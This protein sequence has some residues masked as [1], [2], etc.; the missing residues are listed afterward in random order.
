[1]ATVNEMEPT[2][3]ALMPNLLAIVAIAAGDHLVVKPL[4][5]ARGLAAGKLSVCRWFLVHFAANLA[6]CLTAWRALW[7]T[8]SDPLNSMNVD[9]YNDSSLFGCTSPWPLAIINSVHVYHMVGG[10]SLTSADYFHHL[11]FIPALGLPG[12]FLKW[13]PVMPAGAFFI[14]GLPG[15]TSYL[16]LGLSKLGLVSAMTEKRCSAN[17]NT[18]VR[19]PG[20]LFTCFCI[21]QATLYGK[22]TVPTWAL[23]VHASLPVYNALYYNKQAVANYT[24]HYLNALLNTDDETKPILHKSFRVPGASA[25]YIEMAWKDACGVP[26]RGS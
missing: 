4:V 22:H 3:A 7:T 25:N 1:M 10:F 17:L 15:G 23:C 26:Q 16:L 8:M 19:T 14:S 21:Y 2:Y 9:V 6:V 13:G 12:Q 18:W 24:V 5:R 20:I 11:L